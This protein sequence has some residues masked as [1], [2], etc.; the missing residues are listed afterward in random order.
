[1]KRTPS[2]TTRDA[3]LEAGD[4]VLVPF[5]FTDLSS[6]KQR[7]ALVLSDAAVNAAS[8]DVVVCALTSN[9]ANSPHSVLV[10]DADLERGKLAKPSRVKVAKVATLQRSIVRKK[11]ARLAPAAFS[12]VM[13]E[14]ESMY[15]NG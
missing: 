9:L 3:P 7:P 13:R 6:A 1:M 5:P 15:T 2:G 10:S 8:A 12:R 11:F 4:L 14:F